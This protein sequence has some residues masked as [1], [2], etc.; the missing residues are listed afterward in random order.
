MDAIKKGSIRGVA[1][2]VSCTT[3]LNYGQNIH[4][5]AVARELIK[6]DILVLSMGCGKSAQ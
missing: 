5:N 2:F 6:R 3:L 1:G 4:S